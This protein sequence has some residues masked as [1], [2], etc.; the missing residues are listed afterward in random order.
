MLSMYYKIWVDAMVFEQTK[1]G[2]RRNWKIL[3]LIP[4]SMLQGVNLL[5]IFFVARV[6]TKKNI[7]IF[8]DVIIFHIKQLDSFISFSINPF[9]PFVILNYF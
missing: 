9:W 5:T 7:P 3:T 1:N 4:I 2:E 8:F 6:I